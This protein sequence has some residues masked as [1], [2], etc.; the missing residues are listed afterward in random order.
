MG[1]C[2]FVTDSDFEQVYEN[3]PVG[4]AKLQVNGLVN[5]VWIIDD[6]DGKWERVSDRFRFFYAFGLNDA[7]IRLPK[8]P[9]RQFT[10]QWEDS[11]GIH[12]VHSGK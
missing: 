1:T 7:L 11:T 9:D 8:L 5:Q 2:Q 4:S 6:V 10:V 3:T 12:F